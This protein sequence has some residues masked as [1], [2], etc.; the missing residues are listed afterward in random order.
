[1]SWKA[2]LQHT[3]DL[4]TTEA[5]YMA[6]TKATKEAIWLKGLT[7]DLGISQDQALVYCDSMSAI[8]LAKDQ[9]FHDQTKHID[10][11]YHFIPS[12]T[13]VKVAKN[14]THENQTC[15]LTKSLPKPK[16]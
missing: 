8:C 14:G 2:T 12:E 15:M 6:L 16:F 10:V 13:R 11:C 5:E 4:S 3:L 7:G 9:L 1:M